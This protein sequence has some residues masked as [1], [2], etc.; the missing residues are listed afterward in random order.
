MNKNAKRIIRVFRDIALTILIGIIIYVA[1]KLKKN[2][3]LVSSENIVKVVSSNSII[4]TMEFILF[5]FI[6]YVKRN[7]LYFSIGSHKYCIW[8][9]FWISIFNF[10]KYAWHID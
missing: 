7:Q 8:N 1:I 5:Y 2:P 9:D 4:A 3:E 10:G 6:I